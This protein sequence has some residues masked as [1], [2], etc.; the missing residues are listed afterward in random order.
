MPLIQPRHPGPS[1]W[2]V[3]QKWILAL[4]VDTPEQRARQVRLQK[5]LHFVVGRLDD[6]KGIGEDGV[7]HPVTRMSLS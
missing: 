5:E 6:G 1:M 4:P 3:L 2:A 7:S